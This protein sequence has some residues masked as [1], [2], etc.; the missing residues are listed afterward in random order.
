MRRFDQAS[1]FDALARTGRLT[2]AVM[3]RLADH[4]AQF[5]AVAERVSIA[6]VRR[7]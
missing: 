5:H 7:R 4:I 2:P 6:A 3:D 1:L